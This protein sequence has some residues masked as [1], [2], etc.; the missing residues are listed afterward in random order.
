M[1]DGKVIDQ[2]PREQ[3]E[4]C[5]GGNYENQGTYLEGKH[6]AIEI[7]GI[8]ETDKEGVGFADTTNMEPNSNEGDGVEVE[9]PMHMVTADLGLGP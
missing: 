8:E 6:V 5:K 4:I 3:D 7:N 9:D 2:N 1:V